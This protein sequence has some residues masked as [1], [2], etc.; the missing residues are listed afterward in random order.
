LNCLHRLRQAVVQKSK[1]PARLA[2]A[3][4]SGICC[5]LLRFDL[6]SLDPRRLARYYAY[7]ADYSDQQGTARTDGR[8]VR[9]SKSRGIKVV[10][11]VHRRQVKVKNGK[12]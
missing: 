10:G 7:R 8:S 3:G 6:S 12:T 4:V 2:P 9:D 5:R 1:T 11:A